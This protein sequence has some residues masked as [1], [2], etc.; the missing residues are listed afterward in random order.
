VVA[1]VFEFSR[2]NGASYGLALYILFRSTRAG[3]SGE[4][5]PTPSGLR[6]R[7]PGA[8]L[9]FF[10][11]EEGLEKFTPTR[12]GELKTNPQTACRC[13][14]SFA[15]KKIVKALFG[16]RFRADLHAAPRLGATRHRHRSTDE[17]PFYR[18]PEYR[19][20]APRNRG[21]IGRQSRQLLLLFFGHWVSRLRR[22]GV[23]V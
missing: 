7:S 14:S 1:E 13:V 21:V 9:C 12:L 15:R 5:S 20:P 19:D 4:K 3:A 2:P 18:T 10:P 16:S 22:G 17:L 6:V 11:S 23:E 8:I